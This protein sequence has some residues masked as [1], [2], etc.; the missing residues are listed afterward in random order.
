MQKK[1]LRVTSFVRKIEQMTFVRAVRGG[2]V[3]MIPVLI[4]GA[5]ALVFRFLPIDGYREFI[6]SFAGGVFDKIFLYV[7]AA[8]FGVLSI[9]MTYSISR[10]YM[11]VKADP[12]TVNGGAVFASLVAF[13]ILSGAFLEDFGSVQMGVKS[14][15]LAIV[16]GLGAS[17]LYLSADRFFRRRRSYLFSPGADREF[18]R[19]LSSFI[20]ILVVTVVFGVLNTVILFVSR[21]PSIHALYIR[22]MNAIFSHIKAGFLKGFCFVLVSSILWF[23]GV[24]GSDA[25]EGVMSDQIVGGMSG[26]ILQNKA[27]FDCFVLMGGCGTTICLLIALLAFS[28]NRAQRRLGITAALPMLCNINELMVFGLPIVFNPVMLI[29]FLAVPLVCY[30][31]SY[32]AAFTGLVP[33]IDAGAEIYWTTP[34]LL[35]GFKAGGI[36]GLLLQLVLV[37]VGVAIYFPFVRL[38]D[39]ESERNG[40]RHFSAFM[41]YF[42]EHEAELQNK[43]VVDLDNVYSDVAKSLCADIRDGMSRHMA[44]YYQPQYDYSGKCVGVEALLRWKHPVYGTLYPPLV[45]KL[46]TESNLLPRFEEAVLEKALAD[47]PAVLRQFG[48]D[49]KLSVNVTGSTVSTPRFIAFCRKL[50]ETEPFA[51]RNICIEVTEQTALDLGDE[52]RGYLNE[53]RGMG[54]L[55]AIDDFSMGQTSLHYLKDNLFHIIKI[56]GSLV[57]GLNTSQNCREI[58]SSI[59]GLAESLSL[60]VIA[61]FVETAEQREILHGIGCDCYQGYLYSPAVPLEAAAKTANAQTNDAKGSEQEAE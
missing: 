41:E 55:L 7:N 26:E 35:G 17:A 32:L 59:T 12:E 51:G 4:I 45:V 61:E 22:G 49:V 18:N 60:P 48:E 15:V 43:R 42:R 57:R 46:V 28:R 47:R 34:I 53:L 56:D 33:V 25:L 14:M 16:A 29:P 40:R 8:T 1:P 38:L 36:R 37:L 21:D 23:F 39:R 52:T 10:S 58:I 11:K 5:F 31:V 19:M 13:F 2:L 44:L 27:F 24:H 3:N 20:P 50:N 6:E 54:L 30:S 9:Y